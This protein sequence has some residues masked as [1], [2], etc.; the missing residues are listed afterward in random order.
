MHRSLALLFLLMAA[1]VTLPAAHAFEPQDVECIAP[2]DKGGGWDFTCRSV[3]RILAANGLSAGPV[4]VRNVAGAGGGIAFGRV[5]GERAGDGNLLV[6]ASTAT[7]SRLA[8]GRYAGHD[9]GDVR[10]LA[11][12]GADFGVVA[13][14][15]DSPYKNLEALFTAVRENPRVIAFSGGS[16][17][18]GWDH[19][20]V[21]MLA[22]AAGIDEL[23]EL[24]YLSFNNGG[25]ALDELRTGT[26]DAF[27]G[28]LSEV[29]EPVREGRLRVLAVLADQRLPAA[30]AELPT[31]REQGYDVVGANWR[32]FYMGR[33]ASDDAYAYWVDALERVADSSAWQ[34]AMAKNGLVEFRRSGQAMTDFVEDQVA[35]LETLSR[36][37]HTSGQAA[38]RKQVEALKKLSESGNG[39]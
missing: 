23:H 38:I 32:G 6:A 26:V 39:G 16:P 8:Q 13:V 2:A 14:R 5:A 36:E 3:G 33:E 7:A 18:N 28:D 34:T 31:A 4:S 25:A 24:Q 15:P 30:F 17:A 9:A 12:L 1:A 10:W 21:L 27:T 19:M 35:D 22:R 11:A 20:K 37:I 29:A